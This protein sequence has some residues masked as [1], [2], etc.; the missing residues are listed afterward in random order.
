MITVTRLADEGKKLVSGGEEELDAPGM[1]WIDVEKPTEEVLRKLAGR[2]QLHRLAI[3]DCLHLDQRPKLEE[4]PHHHFLVLHGFS[5]GED[6]TEL[7]LHEVHL[8]IGRDWLI[9]VH[10]HPIPAIDEARKRLAADPNNTFARGVDFIIYAVADALVDSNF[11]VVDG[12]ETAIEELEDDVFDAPDAQQLQRM[13]QVRRAVVKLRR[14]LS[15]QRDMVSLLAR[16][17]LPFLQERTTLY[18]RDVYDHLIR[19]HEQIEVAR[20]LLANA[21]DAWLSSVAN[22]TNEVTKQLTIFATIFLP[23]SFITGFFG[24]NFEV[25]SKPVFFWSMLAM[26]G[27]LPMVLLVW[28]RNK[29]WL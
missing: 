18:F 4:Y 6:P 7:T 24:Q 26:I 12:V 15:P 23:L 2:Y 14:V 28:F 27:L 13:T 22:R 25:L 19:L 29:R 1:L 3:E 11:D 8:F 16:G 10:E 5:M 21:R 17:G 20:D 9:S